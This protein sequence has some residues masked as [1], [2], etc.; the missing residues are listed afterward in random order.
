MILNNYKVKWL[1]KRKST[2][3]VIKLEDGTKLITGIAFLHPKD[4]FCKAT[5]RKVS[6][7][8]ALKL[9]GFS[10]EERKKFW[11]DYFRQVKGNINVN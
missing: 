7:A 6:L 11:S 1:H 8:R 10:K 5:G 2:S 9:Y 4:N 3:C